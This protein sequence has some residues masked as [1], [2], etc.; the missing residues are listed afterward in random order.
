MVSSLIVRGRK[1]MEFVSVFHALVM[2]CHNLEPPLREN[3]RAKSQEQTELKHCRHMVV[4][5]IFDT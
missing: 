3:E 4:V 2:W 1:S 5:G